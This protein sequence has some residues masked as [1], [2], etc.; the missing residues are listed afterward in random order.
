M[1]NSLET[2]WL[3][4]SSK[5]RR[6]YSKACFF[7]VLFHQENLPGFMT[8]QD[9]SDLYEEAE[10]FTTGGQPLEECEIELFLPTFS[11]RFADS[12]RF[13]RLLNFLESLLQQQVQHENF[14]SYYVY[15]HET[16]NFIFYPKAVF[17]WMS[18]Q[19]Q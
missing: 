9:W 18:Q 10:V 7:D 15:R 1:T 8:E 11:E 16:L 13:E 2:K 4:L 19:Q 14:F 3:D 6:Q 5:T 12:N 17:L